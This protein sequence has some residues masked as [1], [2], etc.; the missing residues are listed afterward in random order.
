MSQDYY[1]VKGEN[2]K[3]LLLNIHANPMSNAN[4]SICFLFFVQNK[5]TNEKGH[6]YIN[7]KSSSMIGLLVLRKASR[8]DVLM[9]M[10]IEDEDAIDVLK[11]FAFIVFVVC[12]LQT[13][14]SQGYNQNQHTTILK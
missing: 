4:C 10:I 14:Y 5:K 8:E 12:V 6:S 13:M 7:S 3:P 9:M 2:N 11:C 1:D